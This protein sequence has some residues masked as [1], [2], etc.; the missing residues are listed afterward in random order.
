MANNVNERKTCPKCS[1]VLSKVDVTVALP[2][3]I[4]DGIRKVGDPTPAISL[5]SVLPV[6]MYY[7]PTCR[8]VE[9]YAG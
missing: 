5:S 6:E 2:R 7:C 4:D 1:D 8:F 9:L 3:C